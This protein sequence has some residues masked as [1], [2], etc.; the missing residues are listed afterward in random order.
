MTQLSRYDEVFRRQSFD[1][2]SFFDVLFDDLCDVRDRDLGVE[3]GVGVDH[4]GGADGA[5]AALG[6]KHAAP[7]IAALRFLAVTQ[8]F[9][10]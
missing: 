3:R 2:D 6:E 5:E 4:D 1:D 10:C 9:F 7:R 8:A